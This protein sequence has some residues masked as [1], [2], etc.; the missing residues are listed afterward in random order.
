[1]EAA[2]TKDE[3]QAKTLV[4]V[5]E[6]LRVASV[7]RVC[8][9]RVCGEFASGECVVSL[10]VASVRVC[11]WRVC[12]WAGWTCYSPP[13]PRLLPLSTRHLPLTPCYAPLATRHSLR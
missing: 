5:F 10:R 8:E 2:E 7:W 11:E 12:G 6:S 1:M 3:G 9:W 13:A 4:H